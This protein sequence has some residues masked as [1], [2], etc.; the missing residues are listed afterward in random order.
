MRVDLRLNVGSCKLPTC[1]AVGSKSALILKRGLSVAECYD[2]I[3]RVN[4]IYFK[5]LS[6]VGSV[7]TS[8]FLNVG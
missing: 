6:T 4:I 1:P 2:S 5:V 3:L 8:P 7:H